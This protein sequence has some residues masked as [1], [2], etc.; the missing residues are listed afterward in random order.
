M[1]GDGKA[2][3]ASV[4]VGNP[5]C[6]IETAGGPVWSPM[7]VNKWGGGSAPRL[8]E[9]GGDSGGGV[10]ASAEC[11]TIVRYTR[12]RRERACMVS[13]YARR[14][15]GYMYRLVMLAC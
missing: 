4:V 5:E 8:A 10:R 7:E 14:E 13:S 1:V 2:V 6:V 11:N 12:G 15:C 3:T 9:G